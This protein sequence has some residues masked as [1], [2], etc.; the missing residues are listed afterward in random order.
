MIETWKNCVPLSLTLSCIHFPRRF[1]EQ[2][3]LELMGWLRFIHL[4]LFILISF[5][6]HALILNSNLL[7]SWLPWF[8]LFNNFRRWLRLLKRIFFF[9]CS[10]MYLNDLPLLM[11]LKREC[12]QIVSEFCHYKSLILLLKQVESQAFF[13]KKIKW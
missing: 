13:N 7:L 4:R 5:R 8:W 3:F 2:I 12:I 6:S 11:L 10:L 1:I 9:N